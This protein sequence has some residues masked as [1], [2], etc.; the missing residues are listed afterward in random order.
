ML[1]DVFFK[2]IIPLI[3]CGG[4]CN[5]LSDFKDMIKIC[6][7]KRDEYVSCNICRLK[8]FDGEGN[9]SVCYIK[10]LDIIIQQAKEILK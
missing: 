10:K 6:E 4:D 1:S 2:K 8:H 3:N 7:L 5:E 9:C